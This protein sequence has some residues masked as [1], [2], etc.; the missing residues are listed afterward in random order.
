MPRRSLL[1]VI[2]LAVL[3]ACGGGGGGAPSSPGPV[4]PAPTTVSVA[5]S[6]ATDLITIQGTAT[7]SAT[8]TMSDGSTKSVSGTWVSDPAA[9]ATVDGSGRVTGIGSGQAT[10]SVTYDNV[11]ASRTIRVVPDYQGS[12]AGEYAVTACQDTGDFHRED[13]C[14]SAMRDLVRVTMDLTQS[15]DSVSG[16]WTH[17]DLVGNATGTIET[18]GSL[19]LSGTGKLEDVTL[20]MAGWRSRSTDNKTQTGAFS[21]SITSTVWSGSSQ[22]Q[23]EIRTCA[24]R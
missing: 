10:V 12:W 3:A 22:A 17:R 16:A 9:V 14:R 8:A 18:D 2:S 5:I 19:V 11:K 24:K 4:T 7:F 13:W 6:P 15:R 21:F 20:T 1:P 23:V